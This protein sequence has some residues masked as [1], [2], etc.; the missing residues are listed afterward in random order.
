M[1]SVSVTS[2]CIS[3]R[4]D[5]SVLGRGDTSETLKVFLLCL[6]R[7]VAR[8]RGSMSLRDLEEA[9]GVSASTLSRIEAGKM[10]PSIDKMA[11]ISRA[12]G[13][14]IDEMLGEAAVK[15]LD[16]P[17]LPLEEQVGRLRRQL[18]TIGETARD[19]LA[20]V[21]R[22]ESRQEPGRTPEASS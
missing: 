21:H 7:N 13:V 17:N 12:T 15:P 6:G 14:P 3:A 8:A 22:L 2:L 4:N 1:S 5:C 20:R 19:A 18:L 10:N 11:A 9:S 16:D